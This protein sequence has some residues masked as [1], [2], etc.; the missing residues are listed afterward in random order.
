MMPSAITTAPENTASDAAKARGLSRC[1]SPI[2]T[3][4]N[5]PSR[6]TTSHFRSLVWSAASARRMLRAVPARTVAF[7]NA[8]CTAPPD[9]F[10][11][12]GWLT[13]RS[14]LS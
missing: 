3:C 7:S 4:V 11:S 8:A 12:D 14:R 13:S 2:A 10:D 1:T 9:A 5:R 6:I